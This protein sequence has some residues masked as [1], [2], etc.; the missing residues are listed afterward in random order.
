MSGRLLM[1]VNHPPP[2]HALRPWS[3]L[4]LGHVEIMLCLP[5]QAPECYGFYVSPAN[6]WRVLLSVFWPQRAR[7]IRRSWVP[8]TPRYWRS[9]DMTPASMAAA[10]AFLEGAAANC[11]TASLRYHA[12]RYNCFH[13]AFDC[14]RAFGQCPP[15]ESRQWAF[16]FRTVGSASFCK[17]VIGPQ[18]SSIPDL[19][20]GEPAGPGHV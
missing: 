14:L 12:L 15:A 17:D 3:L 18:P 5:A 2:R 7:L 8:T 11:E 1:L 4:D 16:I 10:R 13:L 20:C 6:W 19:T 9:W